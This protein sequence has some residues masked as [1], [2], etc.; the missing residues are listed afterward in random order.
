MNISIFIRGTLPLAL[1]LASAPAMAN[2]ISVTTTAD[3]DGSDTSKCSLREAVKAINTSVTYGGCPAG[4]YGAENLIQLKSGVYELK[5]ELVVKKDLHIAGASTYRE[6]G[7]DYGT[8]E[9]NPLTGSD[10]TRIQPLT[11]IKPVTGG[12]IRLINASGASGVLKL[13][14][15][16]LEGGNP[17]DPDP[18]ENYG[19]IIRSSA[20]LNLDNVRVRSGQAVRGGAIFLSGRAGFV[21]ADSEFSGNQADESGGAIAMNCYMDG[22]VSRS[23]SVSR[24]SFRL[25][26]GGA[27]AG[28]IQLCGNAALTLQSSTLSQNTSAAMSGALHY[29]DGYGASSVVMIL[30]FVTAAENT[31]GPVIR[32]SGPYAW[33]LKK[34]VFA[35]NAAGDCSVSGANPDCT[36]INPTA[37][38]DY[39]VEEDVV[40]SADLSVFSPAGYQLYGG[41][42]GGYLPELSSV[43]I[44]VSTTGCNGTDQ[45]NLSREDVAECDVGALER[46]QIAVVDDEGENSSGDDR[47]AYIPVLDNDSYGEDGSA[48]PVI[49]KPANFAIVDK[50]ATETSD[51][52][53]CKIDLTDTSGP[54]LKVDT[55]GVVTEPTEPVKCYYQLKDSMGVLFGAV[56]EVQASISNFKP[57]VKDD[58][59]LRPVGVSSIV[60]NLLANDSDAGDG[61]YATPKEDL[62]IMIRG[63]R[64]LSGV[65]VKTQLGTV[66]GEEVDCA[67]IVGDAVDGA[68]CFVSGS[69][70]YKADNSASPFTEEFEYSVYDRHTGED[71]LE[72]NRAVVTISTDAP[73]PDKKGGGV[74]WAMLGLMA[75]AGLRLSRRL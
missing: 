60:L 21:A 20:S 75:L 2:T 15:V 49:T 62:T 32:S 45:R 9:Q 48:V 52:A 58:N 33:T 61:I 13:S 8:T 7:D 23:V 1:L 18:A 63:E 44:D 40:V 22:S 5:S 64:P 53:V 3:Q 68:V 67:D 6:V 19:G 35:A 12:N 34:T 51:P 36:A 43:I 50:S 65:G 42:V 54:R 55:S 27:G 39:Y 14:D 10:V 57:E 29:S 25:N 17:S 26:A 74:D 24:S 37:T 46:L 38:D 72:S 59:Y 30:D 73:D 11:T 66:T 56:G 71:A 28:A 4:L 70:T 31:G 41:L 47:I 69:L 16:V